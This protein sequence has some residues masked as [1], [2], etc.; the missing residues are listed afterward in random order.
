MSQS[1]WLHS[2]SKFLDKT[3][4]RWKEGAACLVGYPSEQDVIWP[5]MGFPNADALGP[6]VSG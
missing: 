2:P 1:Q 6:K 5:Q 3:K 4:L